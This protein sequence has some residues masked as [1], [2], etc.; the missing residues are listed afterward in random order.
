VGRYHTVNRSVLYPV[1]E[2][3]AWAMEKLGSLHSSSS[4]RTGE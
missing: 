4:D 1:D 3:D 2:L